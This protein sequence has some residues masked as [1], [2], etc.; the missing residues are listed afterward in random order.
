MNVNTIVRKIQTGLNDPSYLRSD[1][2]DEINEIQKFVASFSRLPALLVNK[3]QFPV[4]A[5]TAYR[6]MPNN[7]HHNLFYVY[8][9]TNTQQIDVINTNTTTLYADYNETDSGSLE[10]VC[11]ENNIFYMRPTLSADE[12]LLISYYK[13]P[14]DIEDNIDDPET[15]AILPDE[16]HEIIF[17]HGVLSSLLEIGDKKQVSFG[18]FQG[19]MEMIKQKY[20]YAPKTRPNY[21]RV[22]KDF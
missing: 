12:I 6:K 9:T 11:E 18:I 16:F 7:Y 13:Q 3:L 1:I 17:V 22:I 4:S 15:P 20:P 21:R 19:G 5:D 10:A 14:T 2:I 8:S